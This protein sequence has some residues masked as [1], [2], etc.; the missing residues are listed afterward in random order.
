MS[1]KNSLTKENY[2]T[3]LE[4]VYMGLWVVT[5]HRVE[6]DA[7]SRKYEE[8][9]QYLFS[10]A[11]DFNAEELVERDPKFNEIFPTQQLEEECTRFIEEYDNDTFW[12]D[13]IYRLARRDFTRKYGEEAISKM[14]TEERFKNEEEFIE[15]YS[16]EFET[17]GLDN[18]KIG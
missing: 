3:L 7:E 6:T 5:A 14:T 12:E 11:K 1:M 15:K 4:L 18:I 8:L 13:L 10:Y 16:N 17:N 9:E 2:R